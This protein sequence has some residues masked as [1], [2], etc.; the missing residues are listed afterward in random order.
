L[1]DPSLVLS[2]I[3]RELDVQAVTAWEDAHHIRTALA[4]RRSLLILDNFEHLLDAAT[5]I[6]CLIRDCPDVTVLVTSRAPL[7]ITVEREVPVSTLP[8]PG[9]PETVSSACI[10]QVAAVQ[11][12]VDR[13][14]ALNPGYTLSDSDALTIAEICRRLEGLP[15]A[16]E[17]AAAR[18]KALPPAALLQRLER[19]L[20]LLS[21]RRR[22]L[23]ERQQTM[24][25]TIAWSYDLLSEEERQFLDQLSVFAGGFTLEAAEAV[26]LPSPSSVTVLDQITTLIDQSLVMLISGAGDEPRYT[27]LETIREF[28]EER[29]IAGGQADPVR[30]RHAAWCQAF[31]TRSLP[32]IESIVRRGAIERIE[33]EHPNFRAALTWLLETGRASEAARLATSLGKFW[34]LGGHAREGFDR[35]CQALQLLDAETPGEIRRGLLLEAGQL[36]NDLCDPLGQGYLE[37]ARTLAVAAG[38]RIHEAYATATLAF[39]AEDRGDYD[40]SEALL[41]VA[42]ELWAQF[43]RPWDQLVIEYHVGVVALGKGELDRAQSILESALAEAR[44]LGDLLLPVWCLE[45]LALTAFARSDADQAIQRIHDFYRQIRSTGMVRHNLLGVY[46]TAATL[47][48]LGDDAV[49]AAQM[50]GALAAVSNDIEYWVPEGDFFARFESIARQRLG[51]TRYE[52][53]WEAGHGMSREQLDVKIEHLLAASAPDPRVP[54]TAPAASRLTKRELENYAADRR[55]PD[56]PGD[57]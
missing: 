48:T 5:V 55:R 7:R 21:G 50:L 12:F 17:L 42:R 9:V 45:Y 52:R 8:L 19:R 23:P 2:A 22:D 46:S 35:M 40:T 31:L 6:A 36:A 14:E 28:A 44:A 57:R 33:H 27:M 56:Q 47:A 49:S 29:L 26:T 13:V 10:W 25:S 51:D 24:I 1:R 37:E 20:P 3:A 43:P 32:D 39:I 53:E 34:Y 38:D 30:L 18:T 41:A 11:L 16:I 54:G 15:L 4:N